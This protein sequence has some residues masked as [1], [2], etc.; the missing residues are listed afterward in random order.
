MK[1]IYAV[2]VF[3]RFDNIKEQVRT[4]AMCEH[5]NAQMV[6]IHNY[7]NEQARDAYS[8]FCS[9]CGITYV[10]HENIGFDIGRLQDVCK[11]RLEGFPNDWDYLIWLTDDCV[12]M[13]KDF[14]QQFI[15]Q[16]KPDVGCV[17]M[18]ISREVKLHI[19]TTGFCI[20]KHVAQ[21]LTFPSNPITTKEHCYLFE[22]RDRANTF[23]QQITRMGLK[24]IQISRLEVSPFWDS[25]HKRTKSR[26]KEHY[27]LFPKPAQSTQKVTVIC[28]IYNSYPEIISSLINQTHQNWELILIHDGIET[29]PVSKIVEAASD[30]RIKYIQ[31]P[32]RVQKWGHPHRSWA[33]SELKNGRLSINSDFVVITNADNWYAPT[34][35]EYCIKGFDQNP[36][37][38]GIYP[39]QMIHS[40]IRWKIINCKME[41]GYMDSGSI[42]LRTKESSEV[43]WNHVND[44]SSDWLFFND[45]VN[46]YGKNKFR[47]VDGVLFSHN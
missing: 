30:P 35:M 13:R 34:F 1:I 22:H 32:E 44:H 14:I 26:L 33:L 2:V 4:W 17:A 47:S 11:E 15:S 36:D 27:D 7:A 12:I 39:S 8:K 28:L 16:F 18:E 31:T 25:G 42:L 21:R 24:A 37:C 46:R 19:R 6:I 10:P 38:V 9:E 3:D 41:Q 23:L 5:Q 40:Y 20:P 43:G 29:Y 45:L